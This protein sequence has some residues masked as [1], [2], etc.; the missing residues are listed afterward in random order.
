MESNSIKE[1]YLFYYYATCGKI[2]SNPTLRFLIISESLKFPESK[3]HITLLS[4]F[5]FQQPSMNLFKK[6][7]QMTKT[8]ANKRILQ[9]KAISQITFKIFLI[10]YITL[11]PISVYLSIKVKKFVFCLSIDFTMKSTEEIIP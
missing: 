1:L 11:F 4:D 2:V 3:L 9:K 6:I 8:Q 5:S 7:N 10:N